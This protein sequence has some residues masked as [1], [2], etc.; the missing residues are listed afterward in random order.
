MKNRIKM[1]DISGSVWMTVFIALHLA[2]LN[3]FIRVI[4]GIQLSNTNFYLYNL[5]IIIFLI[6]SK[7]LITLLLGNCY[8]ES[9]SSGA[10]TFHLVLI[11]TIISLILLF[12][13]YFLSCFHIDISQSIYII[14]NFIL[15]NEIVIG[16]EGPLFMNPTGP[17]LPN[18]NPPLD[19]QGSRSQGSASQEAEFQ[20]PKLP[21]PVKKIK[22][23]KVPPVD[24][25]NVPHP[26]YFPAFTPRQRVKEL[27]KLEDQGIEIYEQ[28]N[29]A[30]KQSPTPENAKNLESSTT[31]L[32]YYTNRREYL[33]NKFHV[34]SS[35]EED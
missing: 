14:I 26:N 5:F 6:F 15:V 29:R 19:S 31:V 7:H 4:F 32:D 23:N 24:R 3:Q 28:A 34:E 25:N 20:K 13:F 11:K 16:M 8:K 22:K 27:S 35:E 33:K 17:D 10:S 9:K 1:I 18:S 12:F 30:Y 2:L 21:T